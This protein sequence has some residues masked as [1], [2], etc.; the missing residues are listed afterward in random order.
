[1]ARWAPEK[2]DQL[3]ALAGEILHHYGSGRAIVAIDGSSTAG[4]AEFAAALADAMRDAGHKVFVASIRDFRKTHARRESQSAETAES[5]YRDAFDYSVL[6]RVLIDPFR[7]SGS[8]GFVLAAYDEKRDA[9]LP[10]KWMTAGKDA[11]LIV[12]GVFLNRREL[13]GLWNYSVWL[14]VPRPE[15]EGGESAEQG[16]DALYLEEANPRAAA[17]AIIDN[18]DVDHPRRVFADAC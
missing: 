18:R 4:T 6:T 16:A 2:K 9:P 10:P 11:I 15:D 14:D 8:T 12:E 3:E 17:V 1:M 5:F 7:A 13:A